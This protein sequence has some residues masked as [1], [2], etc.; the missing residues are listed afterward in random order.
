MDKRIRLLSRQYV[1]SQSAEDAIALANAVVRG[2]PSG[3]IS[4]WLVI[5]QRHTFGNWETRLYDIAPHLTE[6]DA[7]E[8]AA[9]HAFDVIIEFCGVDMTPEEEEMTDSMA[10][11]L[12]AEQWKEVVEIYEGQFPDEAIVVKEYEVGAEYIKHGRP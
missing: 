7:W 4:L 1:A 2:G 10:D 8:W 9:F 3:P 12:R 6:D 11:H 5:L